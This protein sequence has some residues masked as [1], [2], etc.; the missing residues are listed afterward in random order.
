MEGGAVKLRKCGGE[1]GI[2]IEFLLLLLTVGFPGGWI[3]IGVADFRRGGFVRGFS[4]QSFKK[5]TAHALGRCDWNKRRWT[6]LIVRNAAGRWR[7]W[8]NDIDSDAIARV[9]PV[10]QGG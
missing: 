4:S 1:L 9:R 7:R 6:S 5:T 2:E 10:P 8:I 3:I